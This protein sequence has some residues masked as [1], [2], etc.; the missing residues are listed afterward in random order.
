M[1]LFYVTSVLWLR[2]TSYV[3]DKSKRNINIQVQ[4]LKDHQTAEKYVNLV[5]DKFVQKKQL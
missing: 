4:H 2:N 5:N 3:Y 1:T